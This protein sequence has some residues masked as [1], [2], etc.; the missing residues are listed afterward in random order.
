[1][2]SSHLSRI[3]TIWSMVHNANGSKSRGAEAQ[4]QLF[5]RYGMA[6]KRYLLASMRNE[7]AAA[8]VFQEFA[9]R[10][11]RGD[12]RNANSDKGKFRSMIKTALYRLMIDYYRRNQKQ[13]KLGSG[14]E[15][16]DFAVAN[17]SESGFDSFTLS[18]R[19]S[20][21][22]ESWNRL[23]QL[24][25]TTGKPYFTVLRARVDQPRSTTLQLLD[26]LVQNGASFASESAFRVFLHRSRKRFAAILLQ[27]V[28]ESLNEPTDEEIELEL[29]EL[30]LHHF[31]K[32]AM[33][34]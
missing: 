1:M 18:W 30:G 16:E 6:V 10:L 24:E 3:E 23:E 4:T 14:V 11:I 9:L 21:L 25:L 27:Q 26:S 20:L 12:F 15:C 33:R 29:I 31:C 28:V 8:E 2:S 19:E 34:S 13:K 32:P 5:E 7:D 17:E 22:D